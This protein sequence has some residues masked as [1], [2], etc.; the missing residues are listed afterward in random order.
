MKP[1]IQK[2]IRVERTYGYSALALA[3]LLSWYAIWTVAC[4]S[5]VLIG[6]HYAVIPWIPIIPTAI[7]L[8]I[9]FRYSGLI[10]ERYSV[11]FEKEKETLYEKTVTNNS[12]MVCV[13]FIALMTAELLQKLDSSLIAA[14]GATVIAIFAYYSISSVPSKVFSTR[15]YFGWR[16]I[17]LITILY[18]LYLFGHRPDGDDAN[19]VNLAIGAKRTHGF[20]YQYDTMIGDGPNLIHLP[21]Y[22]FHSFE[23]LG[24]VLSTYL[25]ISPVYIFHF[26]IP[27]ILIPF[28]AAILIV[29]LGPTAGPRWFPAALLWMAFLFLNL[30]SLGGWGLHGVV[31]LFQGKG[32]YVSGILPLIAV[33]T[34]RWFQRGE[35]VDLT[36]L[37]LA[38]ICAIGFSANGIY[39]GPAT[40]ILAG[41]PFVLTKPNCSIVWRRLLSLST[42]FA[43]PIIVA[44]IILVFGLAYPSEVLVSKSAALEINFVT[45]YGIGGRIIMALILITGVGLVRVGLCKRISLIYVPLFFVATMNPLSWKI[46][47]TAT[48]NLGF[49]IF[50]SLPAPI[51][52]SILGVS[53]FDW[54]RIRSE[55]FQTVGATALLVSSI[56]Y[57][58]YNDMS[59]QRISWHMPTLRV[60]SG[61]WDVVTK[62]SSLVSP[63]CSILLPQRYAIL[64]SM[65]EHAP[66]PVAVRDLYMVHYRFTLP[67]AERETR[68]SLL[69]LA[70]G[71]SSVRVPNASSLE[72]NGVKI[73]IIAADQNASTAGPLA[74]L[75]HS[76]GL[77]NRGMVGPLR[78]W[79]GACYI[80]SSVTTV[81]SK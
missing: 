43:W 61:D 60:N 28:L 65:N 72:K 81:P 62:I 63:K 59:E 58:S 51:L 11:T 15:P 13:I 9:G 4:T 45:W 31:R 64:M 71:K 37:L 7:T 35:R 42:T 39:G 34:V 38:N 44:I 79:A 47:E 69:E 29:T 78:L 18:M 56:I 50:W 54:L 6:V 74:G 52:V 10:V 66:T 67:R 24:A 22:K 76:L 53:I 20:V 21:T 70:D 36:A 14:T 33:L 40:S 25:H 19:F 41:L 12:S 32:F 3:M 17:L 49:R 26:V 77:M 5:L 73:D 48:G 2:T 1:I 27:L 16:V 75:A 8:M 30:A 68:A 80:S 55:F 57:V 23:I 46:I